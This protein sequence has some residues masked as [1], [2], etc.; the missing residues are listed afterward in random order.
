MDALQQIRKPIECEMNRYKDVFDSFLV[1]KNPLLNL[2]LST[3]AKRKGKMMRPLLTLLSAKFIGGEIND[4]T[5]LS[6]AAF[7]FFHT[8]SLV[9]D[10][11]VDE[12]DE[13][14]GQKSIN[15]SFGNQAAVLVGDYLLANALL[16]SSKTK[17]TRLVEIVSVAAQS[18][19]DGELLQLG[20]IQNES[21]SEDIYYDIIKNKTAA[22]FAACAE[23]GVLSVSADEE[24]I[25]TMRKF[26]E[27]VGI[28]FQIRDDIF[29]YNSDSQIGKPT[30]NDMKEGKLTLP[31]IYALKSTQNAEMLDLA[32]KVKSGE[33]SQE[34][35][36]KL[37]AFTKNNGG[38]EYAVKVMND[39][40][41]KAKSLLD[42]YPD[43]DAKQ[44]LL[45]YVDFVVDR[46][47]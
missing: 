2:V 32:H 35:I 20:N 26:G 46:C 12:S 4:N 37:L 34:D 27:I 19:A 6:A 40:A 23:G 29:D 47:L 33:V 43:S 13:R 14:R 38:I 10:D 45:T 28:C 44:S 9:H 8:A 11:I 42:D 36:D 25:Q 18:L 3:I 22:L 5:I 7:E 17:N 30:G 31:V 39:Y 16:C 24:S 15:Y 21:I 1:H 41:D